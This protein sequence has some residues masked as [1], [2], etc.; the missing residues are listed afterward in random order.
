MT[1]FAFTSLST[2]GFGDY[3]P[4]N[5]FERLVC[6]L[7]IFLGNIVFGLIISNFN[8]MMDEINN[9][10]YD[11]DDAEKL[12]SFFNL[13]QRFNKGKMINH[14]LRIKIEKHFDFKWNNDRNASVSD[15]EA[16]VWMSQIPEVTKQE[17][18]Q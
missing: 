8:E 13:L 1:Y 17:I 5:S 10:M 6:T 16:L 11:H 18:Y 9:F 3:Y 7:I 12:N 2:V 14:D 4:K 15:A